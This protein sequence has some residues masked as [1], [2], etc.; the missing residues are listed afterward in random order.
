M[1][2]LVP[3]QRRRL[4]GKFVKIVVVLTHKQANKQL[5]N[6]EGTIQSD[7]LARNAIDCFRNILHALL[8]IEKALA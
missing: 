5:S 3:F 6:N 8:K 1:I 2:L 7:F 4:P